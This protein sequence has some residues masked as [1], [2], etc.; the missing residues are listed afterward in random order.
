MK[1]FS[2][3]VVLAM[4][5]LFANAQSSNIVG[6][7][8]KVKKEKVNKWGIEVEGGYANY[9]IKNYSCESGFSIEPR[10]VFSSPIN[11]RNPEGRWYGELSVGLSFYTGKAEYEKKKSY[12]SEDIFFAEMFNMGIKAKYLLNP[13]TTR[14]KWFLSPK[15]QVCPLALGV[16]KDKGGK[17]DY[18]NL[19]SEFGVSIGLGASIDYEAKHWGISLGGYGKMATGYS[20]SSDTS[21]S[22]SLYGATAAFK[23]L[24]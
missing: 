18:H 4:L 9:S 8:S 23:Y 15:L 6:G 16:P 14:G 21:G 22:F 17:N 7:K 10:V 13:L 1:R 5:T 11:P 2:F 3:I 19:D 20:S 12:A 24:F